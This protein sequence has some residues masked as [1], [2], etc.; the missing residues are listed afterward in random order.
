MAWV[1]W[2]QHRLTLAGIVAVLGAVSLYLLITGLHAHLVS[3][4]Y[5]ARPGLTLAAPL[6]Q[7][8]AALIGAFTGAPVLA[9]ELEGGTFRFTWT[10]GF[11]R[12]RWTAATLV[13]LAVTVTVLAG[14]VGFL[15]RWC[16]GPLLGG[17]FGLSPLDATTFG[18]QGIAFA[19]WTLAAFSIGAL[20]GILIRRVVPAMLATLAAWAGLAV[21]TG[22]YLRPHY[23]APLV[24][25]NLTLPATS[26]VMSQQWTRGGRPASLSAVNQVLAKIGAR[27]FVPGQFGQLPAVPG[28]PGQ[29]SQAAPRPS[30]GQVSPA[31][32]LLHHG[33]TQVATYQ[34]AS[35]FWPFQWIEAGWLL[36]LS[37]ALIA[38][39]IWLVRRRAS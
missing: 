31:Q 21:V 35:R 14:A 30:S 16:Y 15:F 9:R 24:T 26:W 29:S 38:T 2:R 12:A 19:A 37:A 13:P 34:P 27:E 10:Q 11:G 18:L 28:Q 25:R 3:G 4:A 17:G 22:L 20:A 6:F 1:T 8:I 33:F 32:Y 36:A 5:T 7:V 23:E 39:V